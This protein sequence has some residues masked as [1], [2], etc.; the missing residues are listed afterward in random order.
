MNSAVCPGANYKED[1]EE[2]LEYITLYEK[3][4]REILNHERGKARKIAS[5]RSFYNYFYNRN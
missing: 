1:I 2:Y 3:E 5:L 4:G